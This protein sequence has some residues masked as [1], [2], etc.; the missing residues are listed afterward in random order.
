V[1][2]FPVARFVPREG[3]AATCV[4]RRSRSAQAPDEDQGV[5]ALDALH[6]CTTWAAV[7]VGEKGGLMVG[8]GADLT[9]FGVDPVERPADDLT[10][11]RFC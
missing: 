3:L 10:T 2:D 8:A 5:S 6:G 9:I 1:S 4:R 7:A 11:T